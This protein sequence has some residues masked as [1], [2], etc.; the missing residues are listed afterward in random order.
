MKR[1]ILVH[2]KIIDTE[3]YEIAQEKCL[4][5]F[6]H[7]HKKG[8]KCNTFSYM[9]RVTDIIKEADELI[10]LIEKGDW[11]EFKSFC[12]SGSYRIEFD[13]KREDGNYYSSEGMYF[14]KKTF[15]NELLKIWKQNEMTKGYDLVWE[16]E[17]E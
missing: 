17:E 1:Y 16:R 14:T 7:F 2:N 15:E 10:D 11:L 8:N 12:D 13:E 3:K 9:F 4:N 6:V 5:G